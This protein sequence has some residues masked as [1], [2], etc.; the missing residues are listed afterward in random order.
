MNYPSLVDGNKIRIVCTIQARAT[1]LNLVFSCA[2]QWLVLNWD[3]EM[4][5][6]D[7]QP[8][9]GKCTRRR[10]SESDLY[11]PRDGF[12][13]DAVSARHRRLCPSPDTE[14]TTD[15]FG[16]GYCECR[17]GGSAP[18]VRAVTDDGDE[19]SRPCYPVYSKGPCPSGQ[20]LTPYGWR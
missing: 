3:D 9:T 1:V 8:L 4:D 17:T 12:C 20:V 5:G 2:G 10:C 14:L 6:R 18:Y 7:E 19:N 11:W 16:D 13:Y 15:E